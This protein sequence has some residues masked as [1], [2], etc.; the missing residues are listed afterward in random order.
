MFMRLFS[1]RVLGGIL[2]SL[3]ENCFR[4]AEQQDSGKAVTACGMS[5]EELQAVCNEVQWMLEG[6]MTK[7]EVAKRLRCSTSTVDR[8]VRDGKL[9][10]GR[11]RAGSH[12]KYWDKGDVIAYAHSL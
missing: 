7:Y 2:Q 12:E 6:R 8:L 10:E 1:Y 5:D 3:S 9:P 4:A 11:S